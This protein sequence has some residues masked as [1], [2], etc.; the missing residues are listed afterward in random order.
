[1]KKVSPA[2]LPQQAF[3]VSRIG[4]PAGGRHVRMR[5]KAGR[6]CGGT[7]CIGALRVGLIRYGWYRTGAITHGCR[8]L[9]ANFPTTCRS[10]FG[11]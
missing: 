10:A 9:R 3:D 2:R 6:V 5:K 1:M 7:L 11:G 8:S 4:R